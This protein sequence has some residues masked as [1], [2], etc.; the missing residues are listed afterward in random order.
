MPITPNNLQ[1]QVFGGEKGFFPENT[2]Q[3]KK[4]AESDVIMET[5]KKDDQINSRAERPSNHPQYNSNI[6]VM[7]NQ[8][9]HFQNRPD[10]MGS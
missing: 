4:V 7:I 9:G 6:T 10:L 2:K 5:D 1:S 8:Y 3:A